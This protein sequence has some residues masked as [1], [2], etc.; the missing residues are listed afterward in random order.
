MRPLAIAT[1]VLCV[2]AM[3]A[4]ASAQ[5]PQPPPSAGAGAS[6]DVHLR[7]RLERPLPPEGVAIGVVLRSGTLPTPGPAR[8]VIVEASQER[9]LRTLPSGS[10][11]PKRRYRSLSGFAGWA[12]PAAID[13]LARHPDVATIYLDR[14]VHAT[15]AQG[16]GLIDA[17]SAHAAGITGVGVKVAVLDTGIDTNHPDLQDD[18]LAEHCFCD[19]HPSPNFACCPGGGPEEASAEDDEGHGTGVSGIITS[20]GVVASPGAAPDAGIVAVKVLSSTGSG[21]FSDVAKPVP[22]TPEP[23]VT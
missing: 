2:F 6:L 15:L 7:Q 9:V 12:Q 14:T 8:R 5:A 13:A 18:L 19:N 16:V 1:A 23:T 17:S 11:R 4:T 20:G 22:R 3:A 21:S 10:F